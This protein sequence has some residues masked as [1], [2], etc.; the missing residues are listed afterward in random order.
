MILHL[1]HVFVRKWLGK[2]YRIS[3]FQGTGSLLIG[4]YNQIWLIATVSLGAQESNTNSLFIAYSLVNVLG[5][6]MHFVLLFEKFIICLISFM[7]G[8]KLFN[9]SDIFLIWNHK[10][11]WKLR[12]MKLWGRVK[13]EI[14]TE[15]GLICCMISS[16]LQPHYNAVVYNTNS[17]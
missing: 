11:G 1:C 17:L 7:L 12:S 16:T 8:S 4:T 5:L 15:L 14:R 3:R 9:S 6:C 10:E 2:V 13:P